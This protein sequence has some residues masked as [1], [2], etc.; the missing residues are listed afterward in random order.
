[1]AGKLAGANAVIVLTVVVAFILNERNQPGPPAWDLPLLLTIALGGSL[2]VNLMLVALAL[3]PLR[4]LQLTAERIWK[5]DLAA[6]VPSSLVADPEL[7]KLRLT[8]NALLDGL[9]G[10]REQMRRL[11]AEVIR[12][13]DRER[14]ELARELHDGAAQSLAALVFQA[15]ALERDADGEEI[16]QRANTIKGLASDV[17]EEVRLLAH[18]VHPR[19]LDDLGLIAAL[20]NLA[21]Q[22]EGRTRAQITVD[23]AGAS[24]PRAPV[25]AVLYRIAQ[26]AVGNALRHASPT[27]IAITLRSAAGRATLEVIDD[28]RGFNPA[29]RKRDGGMGLFTMVE[30][31][32]LAGGTCE[33]TSTIG[34]GTRVRAELPLA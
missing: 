8:F 9:T 12:V 32:V 31:A 23:A 20:R 1:L 19:V 25:S 28:G 15:S 30:R 11:A 24:D 34:A 13:G 16:A 2:A 14:A 29:E 6:R 3:R 21:R 22:A 33:V 18:S 10:D 7:T 26:E 4:D 27:Q 5:G 17:L